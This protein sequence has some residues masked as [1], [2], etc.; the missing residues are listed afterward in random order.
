MTYVVDTSV[1]LRWWVEQVGWQHAQQVR[2]EFVAGRLAL[3]TPDFTRIEHAEV[4]RKRGF[5]DG[6][7]TETEYLAA[8]QSLDIMGVELVSLGQA[9]LVRAASLASRRN[10]RMFDALGA[11]LALDRDLPLLTGDARSA[12]ALTGIVDVEVLRGI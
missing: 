6:L 5:L 8:A 4:L 1:F 7:L 3:V 11:A 12:R 10:L 2:D 9:D